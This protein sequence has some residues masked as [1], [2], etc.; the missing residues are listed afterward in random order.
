MEQARDDGEKMKKNQR[1]TYT[2]EPW[3][4][5]PLNFVAAQSSKIKDQPT[6]W[7]L[8]LLACWET[9][10]DVEGDSA[11]EKRSSRVV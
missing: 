1:S 4:W 11:K 3:L 9:S 2:M 6:L 8:G 7:N 10:T 5:S